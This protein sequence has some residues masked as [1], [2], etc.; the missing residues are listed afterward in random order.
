MLTVT[1][2]AVEQLSEMLEQTDAASSQGIRLVHNDGQLGLQVDAPQQGD[3][4]VADGER[5][6]LLIEPNLSLALDG[7]TL[8]AVEMSDGK[9]LTLVGADPGAE[10]VDSRNGA[11]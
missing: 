6:V 5:P 9:Q 2:A 1:K 11:H 8:D 7:A 10:A 4:I 3:Q